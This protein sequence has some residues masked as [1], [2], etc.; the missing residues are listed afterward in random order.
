MQLAMQN[1][2]PTPIIL[3]IL[4]PLLGPVRELGA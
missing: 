4:V 2:K 1:V 3:T